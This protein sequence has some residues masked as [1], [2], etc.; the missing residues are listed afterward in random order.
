MARR[1]VSNK[2][3]AVSV[4]II[5]MAIAVGLD[6]LGLVKWLDRLS[7]VPVIGHL[8]ATP[9]EDGEE[10]PEELSPLLIE[11]EELR[12]EISKLQRDLTK[13]VGENNSLQQEII[14]LQEVVAELTAFKQAQEARQHSVTDLA[15]LYSEMKPKVAAEIFEKLEDDLVIEILQ[16][17]PRE[18]ATRI[19][20]QMKTET[21][22]RLTAK[23]VD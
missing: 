6:I 12:K 19:I 21:A 23:M 17:I 9:V 3:V 11:N 13:E 8:V 7:N 1:T 14:Q 18:Q 15:K 4:L 5:L 2:L 10:E 16:N 22:S 20:S